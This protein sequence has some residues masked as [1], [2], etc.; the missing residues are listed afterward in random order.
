MPFFRNCLLSA[1]I[2]LVSWSGQAAESGAKESAAIPP[3][4]AAAESP[5]SEVHLLA[6]KTNIARRFHDRVPP[7]PFPPFNAWRRWLEAH[8][9]SVHCLLEWRNE[10]G[11][12]FHAELRSLRRSEKIAP[13]CIGTGEFP[14]T[15]FPA[16]GIYIIPERA[17]RGVDEKGNAIE[18]RLDEVIACDC[19]RIEEELR[20]YARAGAKRGEPGTGGGGFE[21]VGLGPP[22]FKPTQ[23][24][25]TMIKYVLRRCGIPHSAPDKAV[26]WDTEPH[27]PYSSDAGMP[28][29]DCAW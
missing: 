6:V 11:Q 21:N 15:A 12:W 25:N 18:I 29:L 26:G 23:N 9:D 14:G 20:N 2:G 10:N 7:L 16:Y 19:H 13:Y 24:S 5:R 28:A 1:C 3:T 8:E 4:P 17:P 22:V 27:F